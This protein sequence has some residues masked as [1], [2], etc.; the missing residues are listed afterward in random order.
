MVEQDILLIS[1][2]LSP[3]VITETLYYFHKS[4]EK[5]NFSEVHVITDQN[6]WK[7]I[8]KHLLKG[9]QWFNKF[10]EDYQLDRSAVEFSKETIHVLMDKDGN[11]L[12]DLLTVSANSSAVNQIF[13]IIQKLTNDPKKRLITNI[14]GGRKTM[15]V[16]IGQAMQFYGKKE[17]LL[18]HVI[19]DER[20]LRL[21]DFYYPTPKSTFKI[22]QD[23]KIDYSKIKIILNEL[24]YIRLKPLLGKL[25]DHTEDDSLKNLVSIAQKHINELIK[26][27]SISINRYDSSINIDNETLKF[28]KKNLAIYSALLNLIKNDYSEQNKEVGF[29]KIDNLIEENF[30]KDY[31]FFYE[32]LHSPFSVL[33]SKERDRINDKKERNK[34]YTLNWLQETRSKINRLLKDNLPAHI[35]VRSKVIS[36]GKYGDKSYGLTIKKVS[37]NLKSFFNE[38][39]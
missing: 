25:I 38:Q 15:S 33:V 24:P 22:V 6:G 31:L 5:I 30:L 32:K 34:F 20:F 23:E 26:P 12:N 21:N 27:I 11:P 4:K 1:S 17:D 35:Y 39:N 14:A 37:I 36:S 28:P 13:D 3:Q 10:F 2:G 18:T 7:L 19:I 16:I 29:I 8:D 9:E